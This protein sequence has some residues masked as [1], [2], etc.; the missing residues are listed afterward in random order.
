MEETNRGESIVEEEAVVSTSTREDGAKGQD[1]DDLWENK[2]GE[3]T[4]AIVRFP[5]LRVRSQHRQEIAS[6]MVTHNQSRI[7]QRNP[8]LSNFLYIQ[9]EPPTALHT[10]RSPKLLKSVGGVQRL[11][12]RLFKS[13]LIVQNPSLQLYRKT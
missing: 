1:F 6:S 3:F 9:E 10:L 11:G 7:D 13:V 8:D 2:F 12:P 5:E 4:G